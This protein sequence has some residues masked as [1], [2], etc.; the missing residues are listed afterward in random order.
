MP[1]RDGEHAVPE[2]LRVV[3]RVDVDEPGRDDRPVGVEDAVGGT[4]H[5]AERRDAP[6]ADA[7]VAAPCGRPRT[8]DQ[9]PAANQ[10]VEALGHAPL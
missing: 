8:V 2:D 10:E 1:G 3:V 5:R 6:A 7:E 4:R 9:E